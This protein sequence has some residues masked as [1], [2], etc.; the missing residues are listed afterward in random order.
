MFV[1]GG[2]GAGGA[3]LGQ[4]DG[5]FGPDYPAGTL[6]ANITGSMAVERHDVGAAFVY[7]GAS[8]ILSILGL[9]AGMFTIRVLL[10]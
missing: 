10:A 9:I 1:G 6:I 5:G 3:S 2:L 8:V 4:S 7:V